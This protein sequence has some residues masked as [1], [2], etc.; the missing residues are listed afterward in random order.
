MVSRLSAVTGQDGRVIE[1]GESPGGGWDGRGGRVLSGCRSPGGSW[2]GR[3]GGPSPGGGREGSGGTSPGGGREG[4]GGGD[5]G[6]GS[7]GEVER[8]HSWFR[9]CVSDPDEAVLVPD[10]LDSCGEVG[11]SFVEIFLSTDVE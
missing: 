2:A 11:R 5:P 4:G 10:L 1:G 9:S 3:G 8:E 7:R 6:N